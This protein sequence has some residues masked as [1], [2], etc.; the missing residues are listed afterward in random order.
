[1]TALSSSASQ[2]NVGQSVTFTAAVTSGV[3]MPGGAVTFKSDGAA[4]TSCSDISLQ[5][6][7]ASCVTSELSAGTHTLT[8]EYSGEANFESSA[9]SLITEKPAGSVFEFSQA[10]YGVAERGGFVTITVRRT[11]DLTGPASVDYA[12]DDGS[13]SSV[14]VACSLVTGTALE[15]CDYTR[16]AGTLQFAANETEK[17]FVVLVNDD[18]YVEGTE[19]TSITLSNPGGNAVL[20]PRAAS[21]LQIMDDL[22]ESFGNPSDDGATFVRQHYHDFLNREPDLEGLQFWTKNLANCDTDGCAEVKRIDTS[23]AFFLSIEFQETGYLVERFYKVSYGDA[24]GASNFGGPHQLSVPN[25]RWREFLHDTQ[26]IGNTVIVGQVA[27]QQQ[28]EDQ[29][30]AFAREFISRARFTLRYP[31]SLSAAQFVNQL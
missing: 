19:T 8:A 1:T 10:S 3:G 25:V 24:T 5:S 15:R 27:W 29:K 2:S 26:E 18:S 23:A 13:I 6:G 14:A 20:G 11:G 12:T 21:T 16:A 17:S 28:L 4:I 9:G 30:Q 7:L 31:A 22:T